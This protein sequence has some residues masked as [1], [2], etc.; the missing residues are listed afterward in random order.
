MKLQFEMNSTLHEEIG[1]AAAKGCV[2]LECDS[3]TISFSSSSPFLDS[4]INDQND[5]NKEP[6]ITSSISSMLY[7]K[8]WIVSAVTHTHT[9]VFTRS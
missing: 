2:I 5:S 6:E 8:G 9:H 1:G 4:V 7:L 3:Q